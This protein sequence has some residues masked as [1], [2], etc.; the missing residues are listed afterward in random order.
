MFWSWNTGYIMLKA[1]GSSPASADGTFAF[2]LGG[3]GGKTKVPQTVEYSFGGELTVDGDRAAEIHLIGNAARLWH[4]APSL[5][6][7]AKQHMPGDVARLM[8]SDFYD[9]FFFD[10]I[11][12]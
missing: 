10:H 12:N 9:G 7:R 6:E 2:H 4:T 1:E 3:F 11:H 8:T 5:S